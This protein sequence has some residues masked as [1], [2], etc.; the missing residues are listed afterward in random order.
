MS[1]SI[2]CK[3]CDMDIDIT[4][5]ILEEKH[6]NGGIHIKASCP[7]CGNFIKFLPYKEPTLYFGKYKGKTV[8][9]VA[10]IDKEYLIWLIQKHNTRNA[11]NKFKITR[12]IREAINEILTTKAI[13]E[14][15]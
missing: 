14:E 4:T 9:E 15:L 3:K 13:K 12:R 8:R 11:R 7:Q 6:F 10:D 1:N 5:T 2:Y